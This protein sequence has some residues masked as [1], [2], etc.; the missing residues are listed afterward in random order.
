MGARRD[1]LAIW[2]LDGGAP[3][4]VRPGGGRSGLRAV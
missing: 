3:G 2:L 4:Q 1:L